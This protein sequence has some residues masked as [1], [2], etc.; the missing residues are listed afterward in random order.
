MVSLTYILTQERPLALKFHILANKI[1]RLYI[2]NPRCVLAFI[3]ARSSLIEHIQFDNIGLRL[4]RDKM[5]SGES[6]KASLD[7]DRALRI[8]G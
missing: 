7:S 5:L 1:V 6:K 2:L 8:G 3:Q 4:I